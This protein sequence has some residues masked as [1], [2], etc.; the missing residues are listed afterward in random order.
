M[1]QTDRSSGLDQKAIILQGAIENTNEGFVTIDERH[2]VIVFNKAAEKL[3]GYTRREVLGKDL[4]LIL[5]PECT[6]GHKKAVARFIKTKKPKLIGHQT[7]FLATRKN[8]ERF[9]LSI[10]FSVSEIEGKF[11]FTGIIRDLT[12]TKALQEQIAKSEQLAA[13]GQLVAEISHEIKN[14]LVMIG[15]FA[16]QLLRNTQDEKSQ[17]KL[18]IIS[19]EVQRLENLLMELREIYRPPNLSFKS[20]NINTL[21]T[22]IYSL[23][24]ED[25]ESKDITIDLETDQD[26][27]WIEG[28]P[29]KLK[30][31]FLNLVK[32]AMEA[33]ERGG[34]LVI[35]SRLS[36]DRV[37]ISIIDN[38]PGIQQKDRDKLFIPFF[39]TKHRGTGLGLSV[40][41]KI[42]EDHTGGSLN[43]ESQEGRGTIVKI[44]LP[45]AASQGEQ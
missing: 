30:Q 38:G 42:I 15:G 32:N 19:D 23:S 11:F 34:K 5:G 16:R 31:V 12:E 25:C 43:L 24:K 7:E 18:K 13:L 41:K 14:P 40:S 6:Q 4:K 1:K 9:P 44:S 8:G 27:L 29:E 35:H 39:T 26:P 2:R 36:K 3:F 21:L 17:T 28:D 33:L 10:S 45:L 22:E 20:I 37:E